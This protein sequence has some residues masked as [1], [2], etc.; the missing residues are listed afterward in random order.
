MPLPNP[1]AG[2]SKN[3][4]IS[5]CVSAQEGENKSQ[6][7]KL[8]ICFSKWHSECLKELC[9]GMQ[10]AEYQGRKVSLNK[11]FRT[12]DGPKKFSVFVKDGDSVKKVNFG[13][14]DMEIR[15]D[16]PEAKKSFRARHNCDEKTDKTTPGYW[17]CRMWS[18][19]PPL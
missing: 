3:D 2:E 15:R 19:N 6:D 11:P 1:G 9:E 18:D 13:S 14:P 10:E 4:F 8:A 16:N 7:Q 5:R 17:S 12:P